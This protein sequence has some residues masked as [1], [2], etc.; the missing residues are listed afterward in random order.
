MNSVFHYLCLRKPRLDYISPPICCDFSGSGSPVIVLDPFGRLTAPSGVI[1]SGDGNLTLSWNPYP[2]ALCFNIYQ[3][4]DPNQP[5]GEYVIIAECVEGNSFQIPGD[6]SFKVS[7][8]T[9]DG[10]SEL[11]NRITRT[12]GGPPPPP[13]EPEIDIVALSV[14]TLRRALATGNGTVAGLF[15]TNRPGYYFNGVTKDIRSIVNSA[16]T[17]A[18][19]A[20][21]T[22]SATAPF[23]TA[24]DEGKVIIFST[25]EQAQITAFVSP[26]QVTVTPAQAVAQTTF[27]IRGNT[28][29]GA[30]GQAHVANSSGIVSGQEQPFGG[31]GFH[32]F[33]LDTNLNKIRDLGANRATFD[34]NSNDFLLIDNFAG[35]HR[36]EIYDPNTQVFTDLGIIEPGSQTTPVAFN[37]SLVAA[38]NCEIALP[39]T[40]NVACRWSGGVL[41]NLH[42]AEAGDERSFCMAI[43]SSGHIVG[44][45]ADSV[46]TVLKGFVN[47]GGTSIAMGDIGGGEVDPI[48]INDSGTV[49][50][51]VESGSNFLPFFWTQDLGIQ[52]IPMLP[53]TTNGT[54]HAINNAGWIVGDMTAGPN[55]AFLY[56]NGI[57]SKL[58]D[59]LPAGHGWTDLRSARFVN[60]NKQIVGRGTHSVEG[61]SAYIVTLC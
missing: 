2:G 17:E 1:L 6:G 14:S 50:G 21:N 32:V 9:Q 8:I 11:S 42:P 24:D 43:N 60:N 33:W 61:D 59:L 46:T 19:Q 25:S 57:T 26:S 22:I 47:L 53:G 51:T 28:L 18:S 58:I 10:E 5:D 56:R 29:G 36:A 41:T 35:L 20:A 37:D 12:G 31:G 54:A 27:E 52:L 4:V 30:I 13:C 23:F 44:G 48:D 39:S 3:A 45:Y 38:V 16:P 7:A 15:N 49:V 34:I 55:T 40:H